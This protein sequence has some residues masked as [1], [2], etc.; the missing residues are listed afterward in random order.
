[1]G[2]EQLGQG[3]KA[4]L[5]TSL[6]KNSIGTPKATSAGSDGLC[7]HNG[8]VVDIGKLLSQ[9]ERSEQAR[10]DAESRLSATHKILTNIREAEGKQTAIK[11]KLQ[12]ESKDLKKRL[13]A[14]EDSMKSTETENIRYLSILKEV[15]TKISPII[16]SQVQSSSTPPTS[17]T[18]AGN[19]TS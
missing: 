18:A 4:F 16:V 14:V 11:E 17:S 8:V 5:P 10:F 2:E 13:R 3:F 9:L 15:H 7:T 6:E 1:M 19:K 12:L